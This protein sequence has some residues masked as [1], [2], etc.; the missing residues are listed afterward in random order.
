MFDDQAGWGASDL[1]STDDVV[2]DAMR[3]EQIIKYVRSHDISGHGHAYASQGYYRLSRRS[4]RY[5]HVVILVGNG[6]DI[7]PIIYSTAGAREDSRE[8]HGEIVVWKR[9]ATD[10]H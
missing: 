10:V 6:I 1:V 4:K 7:T 5:V 8:R 2:K 3:K 9:H